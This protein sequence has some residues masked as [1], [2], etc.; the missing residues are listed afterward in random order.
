[1]LKRSEG[2]IIRQYERAFRAYGVE[3]CFEDDSLRDIATLA[4]K[5][6]TGAR[7]LLT[8]CERIFRDYKFELPGSGVASFSVTPLLISNPADVLEGLLRVG[9]A[10]GRKTQIA[11]VKEFEERFTS[12]YGVKITFEEDAVE[13]IIDQA[14]EAG[15][16]VREFCEKAFKD[17]QFGLN[18]IQ[19]NTGQR[20]FL[21][22]KRGVLAP[23]ALLSEWVVASYKP[24]NDP[25]PS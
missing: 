22:P 20:E 23:D 5:E 6:N 16:G 7:G 1:I 21:I 18:L 13:V 10:E 17:Y 25:N 2:S 8:V 3:I 12:T 19:K 24:Q 4:E 9:K 11:V 15:T 14:D